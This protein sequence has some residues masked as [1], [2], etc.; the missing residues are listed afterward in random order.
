MMRTWRRHMAIPVLV[1]AL[2][3][4]VG[5]AVHAAQLKDRGTFRLVDLI[6]S[7]EALGDV[8]IEGELKDGMQRTKFQLAGE[9]LE[10][11]TSIYNQPRPVDLYRYATGGYFRLDEERAYFVENRI[12]SYL[13]RSHRIKEYYY[14]PEGAAEVNLPIFYKQADHQ[15]GVTYA[16]SPEYGL[17]KIG[18]TVYFTVPVSSSFTGTS[19]IYE[20]KFYDWG[21]GPGVDKSE[22]APR[23]IVEIDLNRNRRDRAEEAGTWDP[24][25]I[26]GLEAVGEQLVLLSVERDTLYLRSYDRISGQLL[27]QAAIPDFYLLDR[28]KADRPARAVSHH[29]NYSTYRDDERGQLLFSFRRGNSDQ[30]RTNVTVFQV[31][32]TNGVRVAN[33]WQASFHDGDE[34]PLFDVNTMFA[35]KGKLYAARLFQEQAAE[36]GWFALLLKHIYIYVYDEHSDL[37][38]KGE[39]VTDLNEDNI[40]VRNVSPG[41]GSFGY[42]QTDYRHFSNVS[43]KLPPG[44]G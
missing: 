31:D 5:M 27:G 6:G 40:Q 33:S 32:F 18:D 13:I 38:Y 19:G 35:H 22:Y 43:I 26:L 34:I 20:L 44:E 14:A 4:I 23:K 37:I 16:N 29:A 36:T 1:T 2:A 17:A 15:Q 10:T 28:T 41:S 21:F 9:K 42:D 39:L 30:S 25:E 24:V 7:R 12:S 8:L 11:H 3:I